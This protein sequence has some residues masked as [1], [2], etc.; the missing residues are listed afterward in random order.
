MFNSDLCLQVTHLISS[1]TRCNDDLLN[2][3]FACRFDHIIGGRDI[4]PEA[5]VIRDEQVPRVRRKV[6][7][8]VGRSWNTSS[9]IS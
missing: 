7:D 6:D 3:Q 9:L 4:A 1:F 5:F 2:T 8:G